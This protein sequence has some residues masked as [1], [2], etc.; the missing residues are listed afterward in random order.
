MTSPTMPERETGLCLL[1][2]AN[3]IN[4]R[5]LDE[6]MNQIERWAESGVIFLYWPEPAAIEGMQGGN[7][8]RFKKVSMFGPKMQALANTPE[9]QKLLM[10]IS[11]VLFDGPPKT[12]GQY[13]DVNI[14]FITKKYAGSL[15]TEDGGSKRQ[16]G[17]LLGRR[18]QLKHRFGIQI[19]RT[20]EVVELV[21]TRIRLRDERAMMVSTHTAQSLPD[22][23]GKD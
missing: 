18:T 10:E 19:Y 16:P 6:Y 12:E 17:G 11:T 13:H 22:W 1:L 14:A 4:A 20:S 7:V 23:V 21:R 8:R 5:Q 15:I 3:R 9:E 2:D